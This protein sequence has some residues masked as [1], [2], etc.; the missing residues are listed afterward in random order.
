MSAA[1]LVVLIAIAPGVAAQPGQQP[2]IPVRLTWSALNQ[3]GYAMVTFTNDSPLVVTAWAL[4]SNIVGPD[5]SKVVRPSTRTDM[6]AGLIAARS[7]SG[8]PVSGPMLIPA[9]PYTYAVRVADVAMFLASREIEATTADAWRAVFQAAAKA[10]DRDT[11][12]GLLGQAIDAGASAVRIG[13]S[14]KSLAQRI[15]REGADGD[16]LKAALDNAIRTADAYAQG[17]RRHLNPGPPR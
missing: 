2:D 5:G 1:A 6:W 10:P 9:T 7:G 17:G 8:A 15:I 14:L 12:I 4:G 11:A 3:D 13:V 16:R